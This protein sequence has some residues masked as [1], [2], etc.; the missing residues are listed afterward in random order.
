MECFVA[1]LLQLL[2]KN[3]VG[4][5][6]PILSASIYGHFRQEIYVEVNRKYKSQLFISLYCT[7]YL[8]QLNICS[9]L[10][11]KCMPTTGIRR[12]KHFLQF[13]CLHYGPIRAT[14]F[15]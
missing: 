10:T 12:G 3:A 11:S 8:T 13:Y 5:R 7:L 1:G 14:H 9:S 2:N 6:N 4:C 15:T